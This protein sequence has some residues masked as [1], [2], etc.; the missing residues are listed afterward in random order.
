M[1]FI[2]LPKRILA[3]L[4][5]IGLGIFLGYTA[6]ASTVKEV[7]FSAAVNGSE[8][9]FEGVVTSKRSSISPTTGQPFTYFTFQIQD[10]IKGNYSDQTITLGY[11]GGPKDNR[12]LVVTGMKMP[13]V[14]ESGIYFVESLSQQLVHPLYGWQQ[15]H[16]LKYDED[17]VAKVKRVQPPA[18]PEPPGGSVQSADPLPNPTVSQ[19]KDAIRSQAR[20]PQ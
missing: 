18:P 5:S 20:Q 9:I 1:F 2:G 11:L 15:W 12:F 8:L 13:E 14:G 3:C 16:L 4:W 7:D 17:G 19:M 6:Q 10:V